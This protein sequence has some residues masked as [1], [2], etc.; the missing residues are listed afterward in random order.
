[1]GHGTMVQGVQRT[2]GA[3][4]T[5]VDGVQRKLKKGLTLANGVQRDILF[6]RP[7]SELLV[8]DSVFMNVDG[9]SKEFVV[10]HQGNPDPSLY[11]GSGTWLLLKDIY[12]E[13]KWDASDNN[14]AAS[15]ICKYLDTFFE[16][17]DAGVREAAQTMK[18]PYRPGA[19]PSSPTDY[20][21]PPVS[22]G[23]SGLT[24]KIFLLSGY[25]MGWN[26]DDNSRL[27]YNEGAKLDY[28][29]AG[30]GDEA[31]SK[32]VAYFEGVATKWAL[33]SPARQNYTA[34]TR[35]INLVS[36]TGWCTQDSHAAVLGVRP[37]IVLSPDC[38]VDSNH[39]IT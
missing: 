20:T 25:E 10:V 33:R 1:M 13:Q 24:T 35:Y 4:F 5:Q 26:A 29:D 38:P 9:V 17:L 21:T 37:A 31:R 27:P 22:S 15:D 14:Y 7:L 16:L 36:S 32:R 18:I 34:G 6:T 8:G 2:V 19:N 28:F 11:V 23:N 39:C 30:N 3:G 12:T